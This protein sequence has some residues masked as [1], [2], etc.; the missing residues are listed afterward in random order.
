MDEIEEREGILSSGSDEEGK[1]ADTHFEG[2]NGML[3][4]NSDEDSDE[5][6]Q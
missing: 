5:I 6:D 1:V 3:G 4:E 2:P